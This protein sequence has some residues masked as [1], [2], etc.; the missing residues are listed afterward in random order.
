MA[1]SFLKESSNPRNDQ[2]T[3]KSLTKVTNISKAN[4]SLK[5]RL[6]KTLEQ[7]NSETQSSEIESSSNMFSSG[8][9]TVPLSMTQFLPREIQVNELFH[10]DYSDDHAYNRSLLPVDP[11]P[12]TACDNRNID[13]VIETALTVSEFSN[14]FSVSNAGE[15]LMEMR[16][17]L[18]ENGM[19]SF[20]ANE[21]I[22]RMETC[23]SQDDLRPFDR[24]HD[25]ASSMMLDVRVT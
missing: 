10:S 16:S 7:T 4:E 3:N 2:Q 11:R 17:F 12:S 8:A 24:S 25:L 5:V 19:A 23:T 18:V 1:S 15:S 13:N 14:S 22:G 6:T 21:D 20:L 9:V